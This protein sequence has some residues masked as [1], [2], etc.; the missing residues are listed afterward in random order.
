MSEELNRY[1]FQ[2][3]TQTLSVTD[4]QTDDSIMAIDDA[5]RC[6]F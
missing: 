5:M 2:L 6:D 3:P 4:R 1:N